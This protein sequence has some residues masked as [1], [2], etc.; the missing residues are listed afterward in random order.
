MIILNDF[1]TCLLK[2]DNRQ[3]ISGRKKSLFEIKTQHEECEK[4]IESK[5]ENERVRERERERDRERKREREKKK[6]GRKKKN[7]RDKKKY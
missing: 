3:S 2:S 4:G 7:D 1:C 5:G 6:V